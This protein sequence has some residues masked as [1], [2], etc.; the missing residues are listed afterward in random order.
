MEAAYRQLRHSLRRLLRAP[1][2]AAIAVLTLALGIGANT[3]IFSVVNA[4]L[5]RPLPFDRPGDLVGVWHT[6][7]GIGPRPANMSPALFLS[8]RDHARVFEDLA[9]WDNRQSA[10]AGEGT[11]EQVESLI[12]TDRLL[13]MLGVRPVVG[14]IFSAA[15]DAPGAP[16]VVLLSH[17]YW[18]RRLGGDPRA[19]GRTLTVDGRPREIVGVLPRDFQ[20]IRGDPALLIPAQIDP[21]KVT[22]GN[23]DFQ[24]IARRKPGVTLAQIDADLA[25]VIPL[26]VERFGGGIT[27]AMLED[28]GFVPAV[29]PLKEEVVGDAQPVLWVVFG[30][31]GLVLLLACANVANLLLVRAEGRTREVAVRTA[32]GAGRA[33]IARDFLA[34]S[35]VLAAIGALVGALL[36]QLGLRALVAVG[37]TNLPRLGEI[38]LDGVALGF[39]LGIAALASLFF[40]L[41]PIVRFRSLDLTA[42][43]KEGNR[44]TSAG[45]ARQRARTALVAAQLGL[46]FVLLVGSGLMIRSFQALR[47][48]RPGFERPREVLTVRVSIPAAE[49]EDPARVAAIHE[50]VLRRIEAVPG[51]ASAGL[52]SSVTMDGWDTGDAVF[53]EDFPRGPDQLPPVRRQKWIGGDY[54]ATMGNPLLAGRT[55]GWDD[56]HNRASVVVV[57]E[58]FAR[59]YWGSAEAAIGRRIANG[60]IPPVWREIV[61]VVGNVHDDGVGQPATAIVYWPQVVP[62]QY[63]EPLHVRRSMAYAIRSAG[64]PAQSLAPAVREAVWS[65]APSV[66]VANVQTLDELL[67]RS[68]APTTFTMVVLAIAALVALVLGSVGV[69]GVLSYVVSQRTREI[70]VR[71]AIGAS[72]SQVRRMVLLE[73]LAVLGVGGGIGLV[74]ALALTRLMSSLLFGVEPFDP[75]TYGSVIGVLGAVALLASLLPAARA[76]GVDPAVAL[77]SD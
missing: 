34:E 18:Q 30:T 69:Y 74:A 42:A 41:F 47:D 66:P 61:G 45:P 33:A 13:P 14:R 29:R 10:V 22:F 40:G 19:V 35:A 75:L 44:G 37:P 58:N 48:V 64:P 25:R 9:V 57:T 36:A 46:A 68:L 15:D 7:P 39:T 54:F 59:E 62:D 1:T 6:A 60:K 17:G 28:M 53:V 55:I 77:R 8:Y 12:V 5:L 20:F 50:E 38:R 3:A 52:A 43:L 63:D 11:P 2:F 31:V 71:M 76:T 49:V 24:G 32:I 67:A 23:F 4:V 56:I 72:A 27:V 65:V 73:G 70:G 21:A 51:V 16:E 26:A